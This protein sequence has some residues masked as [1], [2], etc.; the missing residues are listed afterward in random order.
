[1]ES[2]RNSLRKTA[3]ASLL[4]AGARSLGKSMMSRSGK[5]TGGMLG[6]SALS[7]GGTLTHTK[8][9]AGKMFNTSRA[10]MKTPTPSINVGKITTK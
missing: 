4:M 9:G 8:A 1:M 7:T 3:L 6:A 2:R 10:S 5:I